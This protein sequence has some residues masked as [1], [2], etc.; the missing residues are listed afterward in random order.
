MT[1]TI[2][3]V[4]PLILIAQS[5]AAIGADPSVQD[6]EGGCVRYRNALQSGT[7]EFEVRVDRDPDGPDYVFTSNHT[8]VY[9]G[10][11]RH[12]KSV[13]RYP[14][15]ERRVEYLLNDKEFVE[16]TGDDK[17][18]KIE[19]RRKNTT[20]DRY[21]F[22]D[23]RRLGM[24]PDRTNA[25]YA[26]ALDTYLQRADREITRVAAA[27]SYDGHAVWLVE[28]KHARGTWKFWFVPDCGYSILRAQLDIT[29]GRSKVRAEMHNKLARYGKVWFPSEIQVG[30]TKD[31]KEDWHETVRI[32]HASFGAN[33]DT[34]FDLKDTGLEKGQK[35][36]IDGQELKSWSGTE[37]VGAK[38]VPADSARPRRRTWMM[39]AGIG[40]VCAGGFVWFVRRHR[41]K[42]AL[43]PI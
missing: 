30:W 16:I 19:Q 10:N 36:I 8:V 31:G 23:P 6:L 28:S 33:T 20:Y 21:G 4:A 2:A 15:Q 3:I 9:E 27:D 1:K 24:A 26:T 32:S 40:L 43:A 25:L 42:S 12:S 39:L 7:V 18:G 22:F 14:R 38:E 17:I 11:N 34:G 37:L 41:A 29:V 35:V 13:F 5:P